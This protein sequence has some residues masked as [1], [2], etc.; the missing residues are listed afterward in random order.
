MG[1]KSY[2]NKLLPVDHTTSP[3]VILEDVIES[4]ALEG[5]TEDLL[6]SGWL[7]IVR[8]LFN[9]YMRVAQHTSCACSAEGLHSSVKKADGITIKQK[10]YL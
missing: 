4:S 9:L 3:E 6:Y 1:L 8:R 10:E 7:A 5:L 2:L